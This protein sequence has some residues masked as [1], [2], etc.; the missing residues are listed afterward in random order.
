MEIIS[1]GDGGV[2]VFRLTFD[3]N[4]IYKI[5]RSESNYDSNLEPYLCGKNGVNAEIAAD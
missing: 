4:D 1:L 2:A 5:A 3:G